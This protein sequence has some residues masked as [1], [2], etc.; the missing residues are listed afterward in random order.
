MFCQKERP[1][2]VAGMA[3]HVRQAIGREKVLHEQS[4]ERAC[5]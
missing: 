2:M 3:F 5:R 1:Y 4:R